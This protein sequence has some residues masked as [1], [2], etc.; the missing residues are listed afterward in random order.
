MALRYELRSFSDV[1]TAV[2]EECKIQ[3]SDTVSKNRIKR[4]INA[5]YLDEVVP[6]HNWTWLNDSVNLTIPAYDSTGT[7]V[8][9]QN[10]VT[11]T[12]SG[13][14]AI[15]Y[16][17][18]FFSTD[19][20]NEVY[21][22]RSH[23]AGSSTVVLQVPISEADNA[24]SAYKIWTDAVVLPS[25][26]KELIDVGHSWDSRPLDQ[27]GL[28]E[29]KRVTT[30]APKLE[31]RPRIRTVSNFKDPAPFDAIS[32]LPAS[33]TRAA[34]GLVRTIK[35]NAT[36]GATTALLLLK[37]GD[38]I[39]VTAAGSYSYNVQA[40]VS[41]VSTTSATNDTISY[42]VPT[43]FTETSTADT[44][45]TVK[46]LG[47]A[48]FERYR[49]LLVYP[50]IMNERTNLN[51]DFV[52]TVAALEADA[53]EPLI[54]LEDRI[55]LFYGALKRTWSRERNPEEWANNK[56]EFEM[57]LAKMAGQEA[58]PNI[59]LL[60]VSPRYLAAKRGIRSRRNWKAD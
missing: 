30:I 16:K 40:V 20:S 45:I 27:I 49:E 57:K 35:F 4:N 31:G 18:Y 43:N 26:C 46:K 28:Q 1:I 10:S 13:T 21:R 34:S 50:S 22:I 59:P 3:S 54:P 56:A 52:K 42:T 39:E 29:F 51:V 53:D 15:S 32:G 33:A 36:L 6:F 19:G 5:I 24:T 48:G 11:V 23:A 37:E 14:P 60:A 55:V 41:S 2:M 44:G 8:V 38:Q 17:G 25:D 58:S 12:L 7:A 9:T 47:T